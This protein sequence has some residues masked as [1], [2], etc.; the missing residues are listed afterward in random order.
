[1][2]RQQGQWVTVGGSVSR[3]VTVTVS[4]DTDIGI[5]CGAGSQWVAVT[6]GDRG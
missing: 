1:M 2:C 5:Q 4:G 3:V 6:V